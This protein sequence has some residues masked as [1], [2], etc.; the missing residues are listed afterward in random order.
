MLTGFMSTKRM[1]YTENGFTGYE[2]YDDTASLPK[3]IETEEIWKDLKEMFWNIWDGMEPAEAFE[4][5][6]TSVYL[7]LA[8][9]G[10]Q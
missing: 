7:Q 3:F 10:D 9:R 5:F 2:L 8:T 1:D 6:Q 4:V